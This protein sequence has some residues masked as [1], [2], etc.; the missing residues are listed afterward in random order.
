MSL[1]NQKNKIL[2]I[3]QL[4][5]P[6]HG[7]SSINEIIIGLFNNHSLYQIDVI[8]LRF[9]KSFDRIRRKEFSKIIQL[10]RIYFQIKKKLK[11]FKPDLIYF[12][13][14]PIGIG[15]IRDYIFL[16]Y[17]KKYK[18]KIILHFH[19]RGIYKYSVNPIYKYLYSSAFKDI[20]I[21]HL[22]NSLLLEELRDIPLKNCNCFSIPNTCKP[23]INKRVLSLQKKTLELL[24]FSNIFPEKGCLIMLEAIKTIIKK[25]SNVR[26]TICGQPLRHK[27]ENE[28]QDFINKNKMKDFV[29]YKG[30]VFDIEKEAIFLK[31]DIIIFPSYFTEECLPL[32]ILE[33]MQAGLAII[34]TKI[35]VIEEVIK[36]DITGL[37]VEQKSKLDLIEKLETLIKDRELRLKLGHKAQELFNEKFSIQI[38]KRNFE[39][40]FSEILKS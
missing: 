19:N 26:L 1:A 8:Q 24:Y 4:P 28:I 23:F 5:P 14:M 7:V 15:F 11:V 31:S 33:A 38:Y 13:F 25:Y 32:V 3:L 20:T 37:L 12:S 16:K 21:I 2:F 29:Y 35:G 27:Y 22:S 6:V 18:I 10:F 30:P 39:R 40:I 34:T 36:H 9:A 17:I